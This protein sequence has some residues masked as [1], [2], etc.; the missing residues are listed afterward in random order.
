MNHTDGCCVSAVDQC[1]PIYILQS[2][3]GVS[4][5]PSSSFINASQT[6]I[7]LCVQVN[8]HLVVFALISSEALNVLYLALK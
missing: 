1:L 2:Y 7:D 6:C 4:S 3:L 8:F 5:S